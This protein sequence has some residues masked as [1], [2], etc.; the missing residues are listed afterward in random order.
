MF[1]GKKARVQTRME[2]SEPRALFV[3]FHCHFCK[4]PRYIDWQSHANLD[5]AWEVVNKKKPLVCTHCIRIER[6]LEDVRILFHLYER[7]KA[8]TW[9]NYQEIR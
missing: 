1:L 2:K 5:I 4:K 3:H 7:T 8:L 9:W 6:K